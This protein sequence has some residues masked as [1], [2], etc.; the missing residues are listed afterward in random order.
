[1]LRIGQIPSKRRCILGPLQSLRSRKTPIFFQ[2]VHD[3][4]AAGR[5]RSNRTGKVGDSKRA[6]SE[7]MERLVPQLAFYLL[8][9]ESRRRLSWN[10][11]VTTT[12][13]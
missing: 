4:L 10:L 1:M 6:D 8:K 11:S 9:Q 13:K 3:L 5:E 12:R 7:G 2:P